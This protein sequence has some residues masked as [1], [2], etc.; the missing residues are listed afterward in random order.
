MSDNDERLLARAVFKTVNQQLDP[1]PYRFS[2]LPREEE[3]KLVEA[4]DAYMEVTSRGYRFHPLVLEYYK[5]WGERYLQGL[6]ASRR[7]LQ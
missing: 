6:R 1:P 5:L 3:S 7:L 4:L 2:G